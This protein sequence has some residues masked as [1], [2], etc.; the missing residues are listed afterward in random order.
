M[1]A[2]MVKDDSKLRMFFV[3]YFNFYI[4]LILGTLSYCIANNQ[5]FDQIKKLLDRRYGIKE[6]RSLK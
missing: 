6:P 1:E 2:V 4:L 3:Q 5:Q